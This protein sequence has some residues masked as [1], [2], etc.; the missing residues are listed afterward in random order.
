MTGGARPQRFASELTRVAMRAGLISFDRLLIENLQADHRGQIGKLPQR[1]IIA[2]IVSKVKGAFA[3]AFS[4][5]FAPAL[6]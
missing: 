5:S 6:A 1:Y 3:Q 2:N 4:T